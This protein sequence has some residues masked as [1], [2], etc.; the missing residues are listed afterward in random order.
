MNMECFSI[1]LVINFFQL[2][3]VVF[4]V[5][6]LHLFV[7]FVPRYFLWYCKWNCIYKFNFGSLLLVCRKT[8]D[9]KILIFYPALLLN[10]FVSSNSFLVNFLGFSTHQIMSS[11][12]RDGFT[13]FPAWM[14]FISFSTGII[15]SRTS[16][17]VLK[18]VMRRDS[19]SFFWSLE[20]KHSVFHY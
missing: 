17:T 6:V 9:F 7:K 5:Q 4:N 19:L 14:S 18:K 8:M 15:L 10:L 20:G 16:N 3:F 1:F 12:S 2:C 13:S 11:V